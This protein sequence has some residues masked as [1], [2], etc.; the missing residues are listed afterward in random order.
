MSRF[1]TSLTL[2][3]SNQNNHLWFSGKVYWHLGYFICTFPGNH[4]YPYSTSTYA[5]PVFSCKYSGIPY[6]VHF[7]LLGRYNNCPQ[8]VNSQNFNLS[9]HLLVEYLYISLICVYL[10]WGR[11]LG[12]IILLTPMVLTIWISIFQHIHLWNTC[13]FH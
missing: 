5:L 13:T 9:A 6:L 2:N 1:Y 12:T 4:F 3:E 7:P 11:E 8:C 10:W